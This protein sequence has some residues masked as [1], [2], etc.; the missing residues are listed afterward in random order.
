M[1]YEAVIVALVIR[2]A[3]DALVRVRID[4]RVS[5]TRVITHAAGRASPRNHS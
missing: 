4:C 1:V 5:L 2:Q 3:P